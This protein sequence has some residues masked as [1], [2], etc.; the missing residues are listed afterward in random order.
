MIGMSKLPPSAPKQ[1]DAGHW[2]ETAV[3]H[4]GALHQKLGVPQGEP[5]P[6]KKL[7]AATQSS[8]PLERKEANLAEVFK[9][10]APK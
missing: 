5:I 1:P 4:P 7:Q 8:S 2:M 10:A 3:K 6:A 9:K